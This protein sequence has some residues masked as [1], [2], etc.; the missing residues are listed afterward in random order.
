MNTDGH[1]QPI[2]RHTHAHTGD[3]QAHS[4][5]LRYMV[6]I[7]GHATIFSLKNLYACAGHTNTHAAQLGKA[8]SLCLVVLRVSSQTP[9]GSCLGNSVLFASTR[10][11][12]TEALFG[13]FPH[14]T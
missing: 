13:A 14:P 3:T 7:H 6:H 9:T 5:I 2:H 12:G 11:K 8:H 10:R 1:I 4:Y